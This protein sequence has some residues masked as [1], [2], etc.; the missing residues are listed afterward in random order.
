MPRLV[1]PLLCL[2]T[3]TAPAAGEPLEI[4]LDG[5]KARWRYHFR[6]DRGRTGGPRPG[7]VILVG[8]RPIVVLPGEKQ[9]DLER[10]EEGV[11]YQKKA[12]ERFRIS[13]SCKTKGWG[14]KRQVINELAGLSKAQRARLRSVRI[15]LLTPGAREYLGK[16]VDRLEPKKP[17]KQGK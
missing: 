8:Y 13:A 7:D 2:L 10:D 15:D 11:L 14:K 6:A 9:L 12:G 17:Q 3:L 5:K 16:L 1:L 4:L